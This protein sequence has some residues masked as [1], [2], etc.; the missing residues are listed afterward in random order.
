[1]IDFLLLPIN[2]I[3]NEICALTRLKDFT[4]FL[5][6]EIKAIKSLLWNKMQGWLN[7]LFLYSLSSLF[8]LQTVGLFFYLKYS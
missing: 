1:M 3:E 6:A 2:V 4:S 7:L 5:S 8:L